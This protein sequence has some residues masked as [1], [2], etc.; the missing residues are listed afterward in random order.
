MPP[1]INLETYR[2]AVKAAARPAF[3]VWNYPAPLAGSVEVGSWAGGR[4][5]DGPCPAPR[6][7]TAKQTFVSKEPS[8]HCL[9]LVQVIAFADWGFSS[10]GEDQLEK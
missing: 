5:L 8:F 10:H 3:C 1:S 7:P 4:R 6:W 9:D 2:A